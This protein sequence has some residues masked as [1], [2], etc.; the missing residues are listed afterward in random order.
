ML[1]PEK[2]QNDPDYRLAN[3]SLGVIEARYKPKLD[4]KKKLQQSLAEQ[5][6]DYEIN[7]PEQSNFAEQFGG[8]G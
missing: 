2:L 5:N 3:W 1:H 7:R 8:R 6:A 4:E